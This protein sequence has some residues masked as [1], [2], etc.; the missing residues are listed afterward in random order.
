MKEKES[1][2]VEKNESRVKWRRIIDIATTP[3]SQ[4]P[5][6]VVEMAL[7]LDKYEERV[8]GI[9]IQLAENW[10]LCKWCQLY[11]PHHETYGHWRDELRSC[12]QY[13]KLP[14]LKGK[15]DKKKHIHE[16]L[17]ENNDYNDAT[18]VAETIVDKFFEEGIKD[19]SQIMKVAH[20][21]S[22]EVEKLIEF[23][24][25]PSQNKE[26]VIAQITAYIQSTFGNILSVGRSG[27]K[28]SRKSRRK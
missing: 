22:N 28:R 15:I 8:E 19:N 23:A 5:S 16:V 14:R 4:L 18:K 6:L 21:F 17:V 24:A 1:H 2:M 7:T 25:I 10:C 9:C 26:E 12:I 11:D 20:E 13:I 27:R 3:A